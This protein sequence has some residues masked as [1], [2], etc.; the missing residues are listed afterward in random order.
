MKETGAELHGGLCQG[1]HDNAL[2]FTLE[3]DIF[4]DDIFD[5]WYTVILGVMIGFRTSGTK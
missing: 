2:Y 3:R 4:V 1:D 5:D